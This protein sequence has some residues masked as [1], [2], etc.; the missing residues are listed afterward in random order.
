MPAPPEH[1]HNITRRLFHSAA[2]PRPLRGLVPPRGN[3]TL[4]ATRVNVAGRAAAGD[5]VKARGRQRGAEEPRSTIDALPSL[6][7]CFGKTC[8]T[9]PSATI[10]TTLLTAAIRFAVDAGAVNTPVI[11]QRVSI[12]TGVVIVREAQAPPLCQQLRATVIVSASIAI[13][14]PGVMCTT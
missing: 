8:P 5:G 6:A 9:R 10:I 3:T 1:K 14:A 13:V 2:P 4:H 12:V 7:N 11:C